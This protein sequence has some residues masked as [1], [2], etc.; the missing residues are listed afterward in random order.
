M[1]SGSQESLAIRLQTSKSTLQTGRR[2][3]LIR[4][5]R[6]SPEVLAQLRTLESP[7]NIR[8]EIRHF[9]ECRIL[10]SSALCIQN[11]IGV[12]GIVLLFCGRDTEYSL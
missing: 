1:D 11:T 8:Y 2:L 6:E 10:H 3:T 12:K 9:R 4:K 5:I 7:C